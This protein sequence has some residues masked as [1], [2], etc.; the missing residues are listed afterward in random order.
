MKI[1]VINSGSSSLKYQLFDMDTGNVIAKGTC[2]RIGFGGFITHKVPQKEDFCE[3]I[4]LPSHDDALKEVFALLV[5]KE[6]GV[7]S[8]D[9]IKELLIP[10]LKKHD[11]SYCYLFGSYARGEA[12][13]NSDIDLLV[14]TSVDGFEYFRL[15]DEIRMSLGKRVDLLRL[16]DLSSTNPLNLEILK[17]GVKIL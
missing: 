13:D 4:D 12:R 3:E 11:I 17:E 6:H 5:D 2:E 7:L 10:I 15:I 16:K 1:L 8:L 9:K 14:D